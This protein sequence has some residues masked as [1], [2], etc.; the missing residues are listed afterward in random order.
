M[1]GFLIKIS[2]FDIINGKFTPYSWLTFSPILSKKKYTLKNGI[3][4]HGC[5]CCSNDGDCIMTIE[6]YKELMKKDVL[7]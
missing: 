6:E 2:L 4:N 3:Q 1:Y 7:K 5:F